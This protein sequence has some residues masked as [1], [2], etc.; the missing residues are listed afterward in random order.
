MTSEQFDQIRMLECLALAEKGA[1]YVSPNPMV[2]AVVVKNGEVVG[3]GYHRRFGGPHAEVYAIRQGGNKN[4]GATLYVNLEPCCHYGKTPPCTDLIV[5]SGIKRVVI[6]M[7]DPNP[8]VHGKSIRILRSRGIRVDVG[9]LKEECRKVNET[10][11]KYITTGLPFVTVKIAQTLDGKIADVRGKSRWIT[12]EYSRAIVHALRARYDAVLVGANT[13]TNDN[14]RLTVRFVKGRNPTRIVLDGSLTVS[15]H[16]GIFNDK[17]RSR[18][19]LFTS[20]NSA[21]RKT[22]RLNR[23]SQKGVRVIVVKGKRNLLNIH[24]VLRILARHSI[25]S[26]LIEGGATTYGQFVRTG[27]VDKYVVFIAPKSIGRGLSAYEYFPRGL[28]QKPLMH[29]LSSWNL[30]GDIMFEAYPFKTHLEEKKKM[31]YI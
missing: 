3:R 22:A 1:G 8:L 7:S 11:I 10:F 16:A 24:T 5:R 21:V 17:H 12:N 18:T 6:G 15:P 13:V 19:I 23:I 25:S 9:I 26:V 28:N 31:M 4:K 14:P 27:A 29:N 20:E 2:G 30:H